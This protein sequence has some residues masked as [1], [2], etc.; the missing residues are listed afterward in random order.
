MPSFPVSIRVLAGLAILVVAACDSTGSGSNATPEP[1]SAADL[2]GTSWTLVSIGDAT[3]V[4][5]SA[6]HLAF[7][8]DGNASGSTGCN[9]FNGPYTFDGAALTFGPLA[10]TRMA[11]EENLMGQE[12]AVLEALA[13]VNG[14]EI[15]AEGLLHLTGGTELV[16]QPSLT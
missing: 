7:G 3:V 8:V 11:C 12:T 9:S 4:E 16:L 13:G 14:W 10:T 6:P 5:G 15:D 1:T 2:A